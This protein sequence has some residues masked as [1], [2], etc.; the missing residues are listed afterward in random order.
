MRKTLFVL[1][2]ALALVLPACQHAALAPGG[3]YAPT[4]SVGTATAAPDVT[5]YQVDQAFSLAYGIIQGV[6]KFELD[7]R[8]YLWGLNP[9]IKRTL[10]GIR[11]DVVNAI[12]NYDIARRAYQ[13]SPTPT[14]LSTLQTV[15]SKAQQLATTAQA[16]TSNLQKGQ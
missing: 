8:E 12:Q 1:S 6:F 7:N 11:P 14:G 9:K 10:D 16:V 2:L 3:A 5:F 13:A 15:L 4:N